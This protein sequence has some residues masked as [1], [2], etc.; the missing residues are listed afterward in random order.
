MSKIEKLID[1]LHSKPKDFTW[2]EMIKILRYFHYEEISAGRTGGSRRRFINH[3]NV[4]ISLHEPH[5]QRVLKKYQLDIII[6]HLKN[7]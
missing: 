1:R 3:K 4:V 2:E 5:P 6:E 7:E